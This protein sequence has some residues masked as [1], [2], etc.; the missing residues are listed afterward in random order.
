[1]ALSENNIALAGL[2]FSDKAWK[3]FMDNFMEQRMG[4]I[5]QDRV[6]T[7]IVGSYQVM[8]P[9]NS[10][11]WPPVRAGGWPPI[12]GCCSFRERQQGKSWPTLRLPR[13]S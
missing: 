6:M 9:Q 4:K 10:L 13:G 12:A 3:L 7:A 5:L 2:L 11:S 1:M 8:C